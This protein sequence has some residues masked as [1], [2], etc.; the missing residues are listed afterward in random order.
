[1]SEFKK[2]V[3]GFATKAIHVEQET[4]SWSDKQIVQPIVTTAIFRQGEPNVMLVSEIR[5]EIF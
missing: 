2:Q 3:D 5:F 4:E 1:M